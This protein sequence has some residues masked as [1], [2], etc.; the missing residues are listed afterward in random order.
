M[1]RFI[2]VFRV[3]ENITVEVDP[4]QELEREKQALKQLVFRPL[5]RLAKW[6]LALF[7]K[8]QVGSLLG[9]L[10]ASAFPAMA[11]SGALLIATLALYFSLI[12][13]E[14]SALAPAILGMALGVI[15][16]V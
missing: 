6:G 8:G 5:K 14:V 4:R 16:H 9:T 12:H 3:S 1:S 15:A 13:P 11:I 7:V 2:E 10:G